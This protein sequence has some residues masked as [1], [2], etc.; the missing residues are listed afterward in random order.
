MIV[1]IAAAGMIASM[2]AGAAY[3]Q[4][5]ERFVLSGLIS[6]EGDRG[7]AWL[8]EPTYTNDKII[9]VRVGDNIGPYRLTKILDDQIELV[10]PAGKVAIPLAGTGGPVNVAVTPQA[11]PQQPND[12][13]PPHPALKNPDAIVFERGDPRRQ[14]PAAD[15]LIGAGAQL[16][17]K[18]QPVVAPT[19]GAPDRGVVPPDQQTPPPAPATPHPAM[20]DPNAI[21]LQRGD[22]RRQFPAS[23]LLIGA[24][25][26]IGS[27][28]GP[29]R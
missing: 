24:G 10:G 6:I 25:A 28:A 26:Q 23:S 11:M 8:Q 13:L 15:L 7:L 4:S 9:V 22:P 27:P 21:V 2:A 19:P 20:Q 5:N 29:S 12:R 1:V 14:F 16:S 18:P 3:A 17:K